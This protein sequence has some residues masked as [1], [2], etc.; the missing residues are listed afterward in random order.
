MFKRLLSGAAETAK[1]LASQTAEAVE[2]TKIGTRLQALVSPANFAKWKAFADSLAAKTGAATD[3]AKDVPAALKKIFDPAHLTTVWSL[4]VSIFKGVIFLRTTIRENP[5]LA[6]P[7]KEVLASVRALKAVKTAADFET[8]M[9][10]LEAKLKSVK[11]LIGQD[12]GIIHY[13]IDKIIEG[14]TGILAKGARASGDFVLGIALG[15]IETHLD[16]LEIILSYVLE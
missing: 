1:S 4:V 11:T 13:V 10:D 16:V 14:I 3:G 15:S 9:R 7:L 6:D 5:K 12:G 8:C 2:L